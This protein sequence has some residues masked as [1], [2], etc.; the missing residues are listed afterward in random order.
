MPAS[1]FHQLSVPSSG[2]QDCS[3]TGQTLLQTPFFNKGSAFSQD[4][5]ETFGLT[6]LLPSQIATLEDQVKRAYQQYQTY[7]SPLAKNT[8][9]TS[10]KDQNEVLYY[11]LIQDHLKEMFSIIYTPTEGDA[12]ANYSRS[13]RKPAGCYLNIAEPDD[14]E[15]A[16]YKWGPANDVDVIVCSDGEQILGSSVS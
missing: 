6:G 1:K 4:E 3:L 9:M 16:L 8:F 15:A 10:L 11:R 12:I 13:F 5:R 7:P 14:I 2:P